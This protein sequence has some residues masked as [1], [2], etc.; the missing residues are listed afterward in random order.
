V[1]PRVVALGSPIARHPRPLAPT[2]FE[3]VSPWTGAEGGLVADAH[4]G[5][6]AFGSGRL[7]RLDANG[8]MT[9]SWTFADDAMFGAS[10][11][12]PARGGG[13]WLWGG[14]DISWFDGERFRDVI[15]APIGPSGMSW[16]VDVAE[17]PDGT[18]W[19]VANDWTSVNA[20]T[21][22]NPDG[23][24]FHWDGQRW[25][26]VC[27]SGTG[28]ELS[29]VTVDSAGGVWVAPGNATVDVSFF[30]GSRWSVPPSDPAWLNDP[31]RPNAWTSGLVA[32]DDGSIWMAAGGLAHFNGKAWSAVQST[33][34]DLSGTVALAVTP[35]GTVWAATGSLKLPGD[36][37]GSHTGI[38]LARFAGRSWVVY[39]T[40]NRL[41]APDSSSWATITAV[42][43]SRDVVVAATR[44]GFYRLSGN[45]W[46]QT[47]SSP[48]AVA[49]AWP[50]ALLAV[51]PDEAWA[52]GWDT[53]LWHFRNGTWTGVP[54]AGWKPPVRVFGIARAPDGALAV[55]T[56]QGAAVLR[57]GRWTVLEEGEA[58]A[59]TFAR[60]GAIWVAERASEGTETTV[61]SFR[62]DGWAWARAALPAVD[63]SGWP[64][65][66]VPTPGGEVWLL[67]R[68]WV[69]SLDHFDGTRWVHESPIDGSR[70][71]DVAGLAVAPNGDLWAVGAGGDPPGW[72]VAHY[73]GA[74]WTTQRAADG[75]A[76]QGYPGGIAIPPD[77]SLW[78]STERSLVRFDGGRW[79][80]RFAG[81][82]FNDLSFAPDGTL[83]AVGPSG[84]Q[85][86][87]AGQLVEPDPS[88]PGATSPI[89]S[90][91]EDIT[92][93]GLTPGGTLVAYA[94]TAEDDV[95]GP[96]PVTCSPPSGS[97]SPL[98]TTVV[99]CIASDAAGNSTKGSF[100]VLVKD[101]SR[102]L[103]DA[104]A[105]V[106]FNGG[107]GSGLD[108]TITATM[109]FITAGKTKQA[110][111]SLAAFDDGARA[112]AGRSLTSDEALDLLVR[113]Q[114][115]AGVL[116]CSSSSGCAR[117]AIGL[118][119]WWTGDRTVGDRVGGNN[120][121]LQGEATFGL[122][123]V[124]D[125]F[126]L[127]GNGDYVD[128]ADTPSVNVGSGDFTVSLWVRFNDMA[129]E[130]V[131]IEKYV[132]RFDEP[133]SGWTLT[134]LPE[135][136]IRFALGQGIDVDSPS[137][138][139][140]A[141]TWYHLAA[142]R[143]G[144][145]FALF[146]DGVQ[147]GAA[148]AGASFSGDLAAGSSLKFGHRGGPNDTPGSQDDGGFYLD[149]AIDEIQLYVGTALADQDI[150]NSFIAG[151]AGTCKNG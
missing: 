148:A 117:T 58:H 93:D 119:G 29:H 66:L 70:P 52:A 92:V 25:S 68:G 10:G 65:A 84:V 83:W 106:A 113:S 8:R 99:D 35:D 109:A 120:A 44:D 6:W 122:G 30:D 115:I 129:G 49:L 105:V 123:L 100:R 14:P 40:A 60:D 54:V 136:V 11:I 62:F 43:A 85:R 118:T 20:G 13:I 5:F 147:V 3:T 101:A 26:D 24:V 74:T 139:L 151:A 104:R 126:V 87:P 18:L 39:G 82:G 17:A 47:G 127:A 12:V 41:P 71:D 150:I 144:T 9:A 73:D 34:V 86:L 1:T 103:E 140:A 95:D 7:T 134:K 19:A 21:S 116:G 76:E 22:P 57:K 149:G 98:G 79:N 94:A 55:A 121:T 61:A 15:A 142:R 88:A 48:D 110:C 50:Q 125:V 81:Y 4:V 27:G 67:S 42:A 37:D 45:R 91:P 128:V 108:G 133:S 137:L 111:D 112:Q 28:N 31:A 141:N 132:Q 51:S 33:A 130:Q 138:A 16:V 77:G 102:Q 114:R 131:L 143:S 2:G 23:R 59:V 53:G 146:L 78:V 96:V 90:L 80:L 124:S 89:L 135:G 97:V 38:V 56:D 107:A 63:A 32:A 75:L 72:S 46:V 145:D 36:A 64:S 69:A